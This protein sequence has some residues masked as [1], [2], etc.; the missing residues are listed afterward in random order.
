MKHFDSYFV[1]FFAYHPLKFLR[2]QKGLKAISSPWRNGVVTNIF[3]IY[4]TINNVLF[5]LFK[6]QKDFCMWKTEGTNLYKIMFG[7]NAGI[8]DFVIV[9][10]PR[11]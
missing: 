9:N 8:A 10:E 7:F 4:R 6:T 3:L 1:F 11:V 5:L 2:L